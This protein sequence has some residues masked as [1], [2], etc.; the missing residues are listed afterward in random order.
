MLFRSGT[1]AA[2]SAVA[3]SLFQSYYLSWPM[4][5]RVVYNVQ[6]RLFYKFDSDSSWHTLATGVRS[7]F[8]DNAPW[9]ENFSENIEVTA[10]KHYQVIGNTQTVN[11]VGQSSATPRNVTID[12]TG[13]ARGSYKNVYVYCTV[14]VQVPVDESSSTTVDYEMDPLIVYGDAGQTSF[15]IDRKSTRLNSSHT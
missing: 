1:G 3:D 5:P 11:A 15:S 13:V 2:A 7:P 8:I 12:L 6:R 4:Q 10:E 9:E 14:N